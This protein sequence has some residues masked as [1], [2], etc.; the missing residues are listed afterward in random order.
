VTLVGAG[1]NEPEYVRRQYASETGLAARKAL[2]ESVT[3]PD[4]RELVTAAIAEATPGRVLEVGCGEGELAERL[5]IEEGVDV[6]ALD[7]SPRMVEMF[8]LVGID[9]WA[10]SFD[11][12]NGAALLARHF[13]HVERRDADGTVTVQDAAA[14]RACF[15]SSEKLTRYA[16]LVPELHE[17]LVVRRRPVVFV[18]DGPR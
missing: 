2:Y 13:E 5:A 1:A 7:Q 14:V 3:G 10:L 4:A 17:P 15:E 12:R 9:G 6:V 8:A 16:D 11:S 18:A